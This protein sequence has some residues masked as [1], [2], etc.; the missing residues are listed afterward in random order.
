M[1]TTSHTPPCVIVPVYNA[2]KETE[3]CLRAVI[4]ETRPP[5]RLL[6]LDDASP[7]DTVAP[8]LNSLATEHPSLELHR[9]PKNLGFAGNV[10]HG[11]SLA[12][13]DVILLN[14][15]TIVGRGWLDRLVATAYS[16]VDV[17]TVTPMSNAAGAF[18]VPNVNEVNEL[19][20]GMSVN[21]VA[22]EVAR[23]AGPEPITAPTGNGF[24]LYIRRAALDQIGPLDAAAF[25]YVGE[26][27]D[28]CQRA[29]KAGFV[30]LVDT[31]CY[32]Y[33]E[34]SASFGDDR[35]AKLVA[36]RAKLDKRY[37]TYKQQVTTFLSTPEL[38]A[39]RIRTDTVLEQKRAYRRRSR[40]LVLSVVHAGRGGMV[41]TNHDLMRAL[42][43][44]FDT[45]ELRC[46]IEKWEL[47]QVQ[48]GDMVASWQ[49]GSRWRST[50]APDTARRLA[51]RALVNT[52]DFDLVHIRTLIGTGPEIL[53]TLA[54][55]GKAVVFSFHDFATIC[56]TIQL[57]DNRGQF[58]GGYCTRGQGTCPVSKRWFGDV[59]DLKHHAIGR[60]RERMATNL[61][62][63]D[64][65]VT[66]AASTKQLIIG[67]FPV[68]AHRRFDVIEHGRD[69]KDYI[70]VSTAPGS[71][72]RVVA[73]GGLG[74]AKGT[75]L[76][77]SLFKANAR[78]ARPIEFH[79]LGDTASDFN[80]DYPNV[81]SHGHYE[82]HDL[83]RHLQKIGP[84]YALI[85]SIWPETYCHTL[86]EAW[87]SGLPVLASNIGVLAERLTRHG[88]GRLADPQKPKAWLKA[89]H[90]LRNRDTWTSLKG[91]V[92]SLRFDTAEQMATQYVDLYRS[93][94]DEH[95]LASGR[96]LRQ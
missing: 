27:N 80:V 18:S 85:C 30:N 84:S 83:P 76:L 61:P 35:A 95:F 62:L 46:G 90:K 40:P 16:R 73:F 94:L 32:V 54:G 44:V 59:R 17:A 19:P 11:V 28:F 13:G 22:A 39:F 49:F 37:P 24:C 96:S 89:L 81:I 33:H 50:V 79:L 14:S 20:N 78:H 10:N 57:I 92:A 74:P 2:P 55:L 60:W 9:H 71:P 38:N 43:P 3:A 5:Y 51:F 75:G 8:M 21:A 67:H 77:E 34:R 63:A 56:P 66:T 88:G 23:V 93:V 58:C 86:T 36:A 47:F 70:D 69:H 31:S 65:F 87:M 12:D 1:K 72:M 52:L 7:D 25:P 42:L 4:R 53:Q 45:Y 29:I 26:E 48:D 91:E 15:D 41:H 64:A 6:V 82:R 68:L